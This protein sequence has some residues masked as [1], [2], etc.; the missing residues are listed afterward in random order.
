M[1]EGVR[2]ASAVR[3]IVCVDMRVTACVDYP[4]AG[5]HASDVHGVWQVIHQEFISARGV[6]LP[7]PS[8]HTTKVLPSIV[9]AHARYTVQLAVVKQR[10][11]LIHL[12]H[13]GRVRLT[14][15]YRRVRLTAV[16]PKMSSWKLLWLSYALTLPPNVLD[17]DSAS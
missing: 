5:V 15:V 16:Y 12:D 8:P 10:R 1:Y 2:C 4:P 11:H 3:V 13:R 7:S 17:G 14:A 9:Y 6:G